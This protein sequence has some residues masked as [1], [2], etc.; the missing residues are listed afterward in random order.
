MWASTGQA[1]DVQARGFLGDLCFLDDRDADYDW[2]T[3]ILGSF[4][5]LGVA[6]PFIT[7]F[8]TERNCVAEVASVFAETFHLLGYLPLERLLDEVECSTAAGRA[9]S[10]A[11]VRSDCLDQRPT[12]SVPAFGHESVLRLAADVVAHAILCG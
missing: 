11:A 12:D 5:K 8:G 6:G 10:D 7:M 2:V 4:G 9:Y 3:E 1:F